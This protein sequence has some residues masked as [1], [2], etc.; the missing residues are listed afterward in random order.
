MTKKTDDITAA[1][2]HPMH[3]FDPWQPAILHDCNSGRIE[4]WTGEDAASYLRD[5]QLLDDGTVKWRGFHF[6]GW[7]NVLGG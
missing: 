3:R 1:H 2:L 4:T 5:S 7:G 6:D